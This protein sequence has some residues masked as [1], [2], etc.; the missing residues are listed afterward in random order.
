MRF[1]LVCGHLAAAGHHR[2]HGST[3]LGR[4]PPILPRTNDWNLIDS[5]HVEQVSIDADQQRALAAD[6]GTQDRY[7]HGI[8]ACVR[9]QIGRYYN[10]GHAAKKRGHLICLTL[11]E[12]E[13]IEQL[14]PQLL[15]YEFGCHQL[16][17]QEQIF[18]QLGAYP[19]AANVS[20]AQH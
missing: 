19:G 10:H 20:C 1:R 3:C 17:M 13:F 7:I 18:E 2:Q 9:W 11:G 12:A 16:M 14:S 15:E 4:A 5:F 8:P 6:C